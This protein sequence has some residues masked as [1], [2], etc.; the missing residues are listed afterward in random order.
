MTGPSTLP[1]VLTGQEASD[2][3]GGFPAREVHFP[4]GP[5]ELAELVGAARADG[6]R[7][8]PAGAGTWLDG[9][10]WGRPADAVVSM[11]RMDTTVH[12]E[13]ADLTLTVGAG[14]E[15]SALSTALDAEGQWLPLDP[16]GVTSATVGGVVAAGMSGSLRTLYGAV[17]DNVLGIEGVT[18][19]GRVLRFGG[20]VV[21]NVAG[22]DLVRLLTGSRGSLVAMTAVSLRLYPRPATD[23][24]LLFSGGVP[25]V[26]RGGAAVAR[27]PVMAAAVDVDLGDPA[28][29][30]VRLVGSEVEVSAAA[31]AVRAAPVTG[32]LLESDPVE[33]GESR[34]LH[35]RRT[36][37]EDGV[38]W[39][40][41][42]SALPEHLETTVQV[43]RRIADAW[44]GDVT[45]HV[46]QGVVRVKAGGTLPA[47]AAQDTGKLVLEARARMEAMEGRLVV[48]SAPSEA[49]LARSGAVSPVVKQV[50]SRLKR[51]F[52]PDGVLAPE[53]PS[54]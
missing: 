25:E 40:V 45:A 11:R 31:A 50:Q 47:D 15:W 7:L 21:K 33:G 8:A 22:Y 20:R 37:W 28:E 49:S 18:G 48:A 6:R 52:D 29:L 44:H 19:E 17:R 43:A 41:R 36:A 5:E 46:Q 34:A 3:L 35:L 4:G 9:G 10:G 42:C 14:M 26:L 53:A 38:P 13:P 2:W 23:R 30:I 54:S 51:L 12:Y 27:L 1:H 39:V 32:S 24:T 16:P